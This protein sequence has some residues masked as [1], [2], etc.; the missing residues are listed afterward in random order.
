MKLLT[1]FFSR[2]YQYATICIVVAAPLFFI[3]KAGFSG[4]VT[5]YI[6]MMLLVFVALFSYVFVA[7]VTRSSQ[8]YPGVADN[9]QA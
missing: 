8:H 6:A 2:L 5:Y 7:I 9:I 4:D 1:R 3:P